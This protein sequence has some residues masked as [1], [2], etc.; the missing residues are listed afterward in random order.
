[1]VA[2][3]KLSRNVAALVTDLSAGAPARALKGEQPWKQASEASLRQGKS[4]S[5]FAIPTPLNHLRFALIPPPC[6]ISI[7]FCNQFNLS[8]NVKFKGPL[9]VGQAVF[10]VLSY[11]RVQV[12]VF[13][14]QNSNKGASR[15]AA[16]P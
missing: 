16:S 3:R 5:L 9:L 14:R 10:R 4:I 11:E 8:S 12:N 15:A 2:I 6:F 1:M 7:R 13:M